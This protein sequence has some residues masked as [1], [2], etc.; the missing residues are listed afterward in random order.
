MKTDSY[1]TR[2]SPNIIFMTAGD[3]ILWGESW[4]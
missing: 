2:N 1:E 3:P 4:F